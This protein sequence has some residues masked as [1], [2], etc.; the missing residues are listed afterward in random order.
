[1]RPAVQLAGLQIGSAVAPRSARKMKR[2]RT[3]DQNGTASARQGIAERVRQRVLSRPCSLADTRSGAGCVYRSFFSSASIDLT[4]F[5]RLGYYSLLYNH[6]TTLRC[7]FTGLCDKGVS[8]HRRGA[9]AIPLRRG[10]LPA[11]R[12]VQIPRFTVHHLWHQA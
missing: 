11:A 2:A 6:I 4:C 9:D 1:M 8:V 3:E 5:V 10:P 12:H 7:S